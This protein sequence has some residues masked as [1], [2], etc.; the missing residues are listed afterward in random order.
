MD[1][2]PFWIFFVTAAGV[3][4]LIFGSFATAVA[5]RVPRDE[6]IST[7]RS[8]CPSCG[9]TITA[10]QNVPFFSYVV[11]RGRCKHCGER[12]SI[13]YPLIEL[14]TAALFVAAAWRFEVSAEAVIYAGFFWTLVVLTVIDLEYKLLPNRIVF[15]TF[16]AGWVALS[17][18]AL[19]GGDAGRLRDAAIGAAI[20]GGFFFLVASIYPAGMGGGDVK[21]AFVL[22]TFL[23]HAGGPGVVLVGMFLSFLSGA[24]IGVIV[25]KVTGGDRKKQ[26]P[27]GPFLALGTILAIL[28]GRGL[29]DAYLGAF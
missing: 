12:I 5:Y 28:W 18:A 13:R 7:G 17:I 9:N 22:G 3:L 24:I 25:M 26:V 23:G 10:I 29:L 4:G 20:F 2:G 19:A 21:L 1:S 8:K 11:L 15:P 27:F 16:I 6:S 14:A